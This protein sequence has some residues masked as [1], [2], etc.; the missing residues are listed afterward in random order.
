MHSQQLFLRINPSRFHFLKFI[1]EGY[2]NLAILSVYDHQQGLVILR[3]APTEVEQ[4][5]ALLNDLATQLA[6]T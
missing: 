4:V 2:D 6:P 1:L 3:F 5:F